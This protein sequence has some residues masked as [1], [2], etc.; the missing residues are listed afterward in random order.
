[1]LAHIPIFLPDETKDGHKPQVL[2]CPFCAY[3]IQNDPAYL[4]HIVSTHY[5]TNFASGACLGAVTTLGQQTKRQIS[6]CPRLAALPEKSSQESV[7]G[8]GSPKK[9]THGS[10]G[11]KSKHGGSKNKQSHQ[12]GKLQPG[13]ATSQE[14]SQTSNRCLTCAAGVSQEST[15][16]SSKHH[17]SGKKKAKKMHKKKK[18]SK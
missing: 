7:R 8:E 14:D 3:T 16:G 12:S 1:M 2:C 9:H 15:T 6:E 10:S 11:S 4:N 5:H 17:S 18:S 13:E